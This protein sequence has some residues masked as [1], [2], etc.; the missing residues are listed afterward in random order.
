M[1]CRI[2]LSKIFN[3]KQAKLISYLKNDWNL[4]VA[5]K[6]TVALIEKLDTLSLQPNIGKPSSKNQGVRSLLI[7]KHNRVFYKFKNNDIIIINMFD[8]GIHPNK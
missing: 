1:A 6:Y 8:T 3:K 7:S 5:D 4:R 2:I